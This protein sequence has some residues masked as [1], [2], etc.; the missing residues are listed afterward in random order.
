[1]GPVEKI[2]REKL[3]SILMPP[4]LEIECESHMHGLPK[5]AEKHFKLVAV[6]E[7]FRGQSRIDRQR[8][9]NS[10]LADEL[11]SHVHALTMQL[12][13]PE[14]WREK[15]SEALRASPACLGGGKQRS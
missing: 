6:S 11:S 1:M 2:M 14:E 12:F 7:T 13:T 10:I 4:V 3:N 5:D 9:I 8:M 15:G